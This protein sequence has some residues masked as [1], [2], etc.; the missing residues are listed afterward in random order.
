MIISV[1]M[2][3]CWYCALLKVLTQL[4]CRLAIVFVIHEELIDTYEYYI[5]GQHLD[6][7]H[8]EFNY[9]C[10]EKVIGTLNINM[11][12]IWGVAIDEFYL[13]LNLCCK[14]TMC[15]VWRERSYADGPICLADSKDMDTPRT[16][17]SE[18]ERIHEK[19]R[20]ASVEDE[21]DED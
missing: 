4:L 1:Q 19:P 17:S 9:C 11:D 10:Q 8:P 20:W 15:S 3:S 7:S 13:Y 12:G 2:H 6:S 18:L 16:R 14:T 21:L 5:S